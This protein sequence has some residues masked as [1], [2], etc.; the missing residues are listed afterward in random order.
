MREQ[1]ADRGLGAPLH[2]EAAGAGACERA[3]E[4]RRDPPTPRLVVGP[5]R[6]RGGTA[7]AGRC[8]VRHSLRGAHAVDHPLV[9]LERGRAPR[10]DPVLFEDEPVLAAQV[11]AELDDALGE[12]EAGHHVGDE[13]EGVTPDLARDRARIGLVLERADGIGVRVVDELPREEGVEE[14]LDRRG[15]ARRVEHL[16]T[17]GRRPSRR[18]RVPR[19]RRDDAAVRGGR[20]RSPGARSSRDPSRSPSRRAPRR[21][22]RRSRVRSSSPRCCHPH[23]AR[24]RGRRRGGARCRCG[25]RG[26]RPSGRRAG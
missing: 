4:P 10:E 24:A 18:R 17:Q 1:R 25:A 14:R 7:T 11:P 26:P 9:A 19:G 16:R 8:A 12:R 5:E 3:A 23:A 6:G 13:E 21:G 2:H 15:R 20:P 22:S